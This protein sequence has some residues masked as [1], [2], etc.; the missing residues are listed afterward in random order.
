ME[1]TLVLLKPDAIQRGVS[2]TIMSRLEAKGLRFAAIKL[3]EITEELAHRHYYEHVD[4]PFFKG[5]VAFI[6]SGPI[7]ALIVEG[8]NAV[9]AVRT[10]M[11]S[12]NPQEAS[13]GTIR[14]D[15]G[16][17]IGMNLIHGSDSLESAEREID[18]FFA[19]EEIVSYSRAIDTWITE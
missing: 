9:G 19:K 4:K 14:G 1:K 3:M 6:T 15:Y 7:I 11:G 16:M 5:L 18:L 12:T 13:C 10:T 8:E 17:T 2:G